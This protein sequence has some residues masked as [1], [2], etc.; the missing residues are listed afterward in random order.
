M[1]LNSQWNSNTE[2]II[3]AGNNHCSK[4]FALKLYKYI[5]DTVLVAFWNIMPWK[6]GYF[7]KLFLTKNVGKFIHVIS[8]FYQSWYWKIKVALIWIPC[9]IENLARH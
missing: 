1:T 9:R 4:F 6:C 8:S 3:K 2:S 5:A 7:I